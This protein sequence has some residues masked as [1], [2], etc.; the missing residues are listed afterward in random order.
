MVLLDLVAPQTV[1]SLLMATVHLAAREDT[2]R[3]KA[4]LENA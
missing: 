2:L 3:A 1:F 4:R